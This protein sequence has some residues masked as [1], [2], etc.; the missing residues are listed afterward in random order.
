MS[1]YILYKLPVMFC[2][3]Y[4]SL[5]LFLCSLFWFLLIYFI[6]LCLVIFSLCLYVFVCLSVSSIPFLHSLT[7]PFPLISFPFPI[8]PHNSLTHTFPSSTSIP[9]TFLLSFLFTI[10]PLLFLYTPPSLSLSSYPSL[11][12]LHLFSTRPSIHSRHL[13]L[14]PF[15]SLH[16]RLPSQ[17]WL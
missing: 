7:P 13:S 6:F 16:V 15:S 8:F 4:F 5:L 14:R 17:L 9:L 12:T 3:V 10:L 2:V 11:S 1:R